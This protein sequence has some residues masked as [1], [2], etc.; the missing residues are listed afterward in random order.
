MWALKNL[1]LC[2]A[3]K[4][5]IAQKT[6]Y[7]TRILHVIQHFRSAMEV[8]KNS[9]YALVRLYKTG[10]RLQQ[11]TA[12]ICFCLHRRQ[13]VKNG[14]QCDHILE[15]VNKITQDFLQTNLK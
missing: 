11:I 10:E 4:N 14:W 6:P 3:C 13:Q 2:R 9:K 7:N 15:C 1:D 8:L 5:I 12:N